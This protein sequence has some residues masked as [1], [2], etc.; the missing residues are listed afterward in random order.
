MPQAWN[1]RGRSEDGGTARRRGSMPC[2]GLRQFG[3]GIDEDERAAA[4][5]HEL[6]DRVELLRRSDRARMHDHQHVDVGGNAR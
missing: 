3:I 1:S 2:S 6:I 4:L 5:Q